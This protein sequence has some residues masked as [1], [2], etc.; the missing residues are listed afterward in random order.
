LADDPPQGWDAEALRGLLDAAMPFT[1]EDVFGTDAE[2]LEAAVERLASLQPLEYDCRR[3]AEAKRLGVRVPKL[4]REVEHRRKET[5]GET[6]GVGQAVVFRDVEP[7][8]EPVDG[9][10]LL[11]DLAA[12]FR[13]FLALP[14]GAAEAMAPWVLHAH[15]HDASAISPLLAFTS[16]EKQCGKTTAL[17]VLTALVPRPLPIANVTMA[18]LFRSVEKWRPT[19]LIDEADTFLRDNDGLRGVLNSGHWRDMAYLVRTVGDNHEPRVFRTWAPKAIAQVGRL[20][21][22]LENRAIVVHM[23]RRRED[24]HVERFRSDRDNGLADLARKCARWAADNLDALRESD[25]EVPRELHDRAADNW[26]PLLAIADLAGG[27][28]P[29]TARRVALELSR[30]DQ[31]EGSHRVALLAD[32]RSVF[33]ERAADRLPSQVLC[34]ALAAMEERPWGEWRKGRP[35]TPHSLARLLSPFRIAPKT[36][37]VGAETAKGY[38]R[39]DFEDTFTRYL[40]GTPSQT[41]TTSQAKQGKAFDEFQTVTREND[42]T[43]SNRPKTA[44]TKGCD[45]VTVE[46]GGAEQEGQWEVLL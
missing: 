1:P 41:V 25:P 11:N 9:I 34:D 45:G 38:V 35:L 32:I 23:R 10:A 7:W 5:G 22:T 20:H 37:R 3:R 2:S 27:P 24:E 21:G 13:R 30:D 16:P 28:W 42:V 39:A 14:H 29:E 4:D 36:M 40:P 31:D 26:R 46:N 44:V 8:P 12:T 19:V 43:V 15:A 17:C 33:E 18:A 6:D